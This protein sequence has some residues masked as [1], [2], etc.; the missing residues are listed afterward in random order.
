M[1][2]SLFSGLGDGH[3]GRHILEGT[4]QFSNTAMC[5]LMVDLFNPGLMSGSPLV[6]QYTDQVMGMVIAVN[7][8]GGPLLLGV[9]LIGTIVQLAESAAEFPKISEYQ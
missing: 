1:K 2:V 7:P 3:G 9:H 6:S 5:V 4:V 8:R